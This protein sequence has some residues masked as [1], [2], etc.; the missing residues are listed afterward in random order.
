MQGHYASM[1]ADLISGDSH[2]TSAIELFP[3]QVL[4]FRA[5]PSWRARGRNKSPVLL[6][7]PAL[8]SRYPPPLLA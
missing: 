6:G 8:L 5:C 7:N 4:E 3:S 2:V 1:S